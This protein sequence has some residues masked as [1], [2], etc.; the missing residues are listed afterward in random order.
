MPCL[1]NR[2]PHG[3][4]AAISV[5]ASSAR[6]TTRPSS[7]TSATSPMLSAS[8]TPTRR[9]VSIS[10]CE[11]DAPISLGRSQLTPMSQFD[12]PMFTKITRKT[13]D[14]AA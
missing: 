3:A 7:T 5:A 9:P 14:F 8:S 1:V 6:S 10:S 13:A 12:T 2:I 11:R 4:Q